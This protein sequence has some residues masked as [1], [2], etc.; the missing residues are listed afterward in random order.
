MKSVEE[1]SVAGVELDDDTVMQYLL[2]NPDFFIRNARRV[3]Q[4]RVPHP[5]RGTV[6]LV[7]WHLA[8]QRNHIDRLEEEITLLMEQA[9]ANE[10]LFAS[11]LHLQANLATA[12]SLQDMLN[13]LQRWAR[14]FGLAGANIRLFADRWN[15]GAPS[16]FTHLALARSAFEPLRI[17]R[18]GSEQHFLGSLNGPELLLL[19]PQAKQV[20]SVALSMLGDDGELGMVIFSS[21][22]TQHYQQGMGTVMLNQLAR[23]LPELLERWIERA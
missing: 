12:E 6:S 5:V 10:T 13:R 21:R 16:D 17:Q 19:L 8:R 14:G 20:G 18:L 7:E 15:I 4:M 23:M 22:D 9:S 11:L 1:Q 3:E 2:Q